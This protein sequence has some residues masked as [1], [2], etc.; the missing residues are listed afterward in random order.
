MRLTKHDA[1]FSCIYTLEVHD[2][3]MVNVPLSRTQRAL[4]E[5]CDR[6]DASIAER[7]LGLSAVARA[8]QQAKEDREVAE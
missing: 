7:L 6:D 1:E 8:I 4:I 2:L 5:K 3:D